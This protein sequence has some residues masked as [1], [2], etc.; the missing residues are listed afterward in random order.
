MLDVPDL[1]GRT[2]LMWAAAD[3]DNRNAGDL[4]KALVRHG[5][6]LAYEDDRG[7]NVLHVAVA[8][9]NSKSVET[10]LQLGADVTA[11]DA[12]GRNALALAAFLGHV[13]EF[14]VLLQCPSKK[15]E[16]LSRRDTA[17]RSPL[18]LASQGGHSKLLELLLCH[19]PE[20][21]SIDLGDVF[22]RSPLIVAA[23]G[24]FVGC[25]KLLLAEVS[26]KA[27]G[28]AENVYFLFSP[29]AATSIG[30]TTRACVVFTGLSCEAIW[31]QLN[32]CWRPALLRITSL[33]GFKKKRS[34]FILRPWVR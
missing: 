8:A 32:V 2:A 22:G 27:K 7:W 24:G 14:E 4:F 19:R 26:R 9:Q 29:R 21:S 10:L 23:Y 20:D 34:L 3:T 13:N 5:S 33:K 6:S 30:K 16:S 12:E 1:S 11:V 31:T 17:G 25:I 18:H 28:D 15:F